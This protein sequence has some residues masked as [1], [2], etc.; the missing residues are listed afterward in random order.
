MFSDFYECFFSIWLVFNVCLNK[1]IRYVNCHKIS[2]LFDSKTAVIRH[3]RFCDLFH[4]KQNVDTF[5]VKSWSTYWQLFFLFFYCS[6][7]VWLVFNVSLNNW[8]EYVSCHNILFLFEAKT[9]V[10][11]C[12]SVI[13]IGCAASSWSVY[14]H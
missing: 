5:L 12:D 14:L 9:V 2:S 11:R 8:I 7:S 4:I 6:F 1:C 13:A 10:I 3:K